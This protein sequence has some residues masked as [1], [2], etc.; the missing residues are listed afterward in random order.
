MNTLQSQ[1]NC[2]WD[3]NREPF[4]VYS[5]YDEIIEG[6]SKLLKFYAFI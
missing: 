1:I 4:M 5:S 2:F 6:K 3:P